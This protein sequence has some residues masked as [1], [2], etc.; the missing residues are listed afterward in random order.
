M[1]SKKAMFG[2]SVFKRSI[3]ND[4]IGVI[5]QHLAANFS[6]PIII[7]VDEPELHNWLLRGR[8]SPEHAKAVIERTAAERTSA[9]KRVLRRLNLDIPVHT[10]AMISADPAYLR[11]VEAAKAFYSSD[12]EFHFDINQQLRTY[13]ERYIHW[14]EHKLGR[15]LTREEL[16]EAALFLLEE[17][18]GLAYLH[19]EL[20]YSTDVYPDENSF[21]MHNVFTGSKYPGLGQALKVEPAVYEYIVHPQR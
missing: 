17:V 21:I 18:A 1:Q 7:L 20:G 9:I 15:P 8:D 11:N 4:I 12:Q 16:D 13:L 19:F 6:N 14:A 3:N 2:I 10:W 5:A